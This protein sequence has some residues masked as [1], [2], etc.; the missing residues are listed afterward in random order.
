MEPARTK[1]EIRSEFEETWEEYNHAL[2]NW[3][4]AL[5]WWYDTTNKTLVTYRA[6]YQRALETD[7]EVLK[8]IS[9]SWQNTWE[10]I[11]PTYIRQQTSMI[12]NIFGNTNIKTIN[13]F[14]EQWEKFLKTS[15]SDSITVYQE[16]IKKFN[17]ALV[18]C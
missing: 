6:A 1:E 3:K 15:S 7:A 10:V 12:E 14:N 2:D 8:R 4:D 18:V 5:A 9:A 13:K 17:Q 16:A 11:G